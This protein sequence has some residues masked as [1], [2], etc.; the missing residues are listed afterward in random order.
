MFL[1]MNNIVKIFGLISFI[2]F[3]LPVEEFLDES[4]LLFL[5][6]S[7]LPIYLVLN[8]L[9]VN[10]FHNSIFLRIFSKVSHYLMSIFLSW[11]IILLQMKY[12]YYR[13]YFIGMRYS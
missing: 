8:S 2:V 4:T 7:F 10:Y 3:T 9:L 13:V 5:D 12:T 1:T 11:F 6:L